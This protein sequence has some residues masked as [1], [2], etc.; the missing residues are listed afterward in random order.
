MPATWRLSPE[1]VNGWADADKEARVD[2]AGSRSHAAR[3]LSQRRPI[4]FASTG[5]HGAAGRRFRGGRDR[6]HVVRTERLGRAAQGSPARPGFPGA[7]TRR[8]WGFSAIRGPR[9]TVARA[10]RSMAASCRCLRQSPNGDAVPYR[11][12]PVP[13]A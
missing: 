7:K 12:P 10:T 2:T 4:G 13:P 5:R 9:S 6:L 1:G 3:T 8:G 11:L